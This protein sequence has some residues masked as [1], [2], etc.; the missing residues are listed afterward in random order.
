MLSSIQ[1]LHPYPGLDLWQFPQELV[2]NYPLSKA[3]PGIMG[4]QIR[5]WYQ[6]GRLYPGYSISVCKGA[7]TNV[8]R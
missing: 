8:P 3:A 2:V 5:T 4:H 1:S 7:Y 6:G